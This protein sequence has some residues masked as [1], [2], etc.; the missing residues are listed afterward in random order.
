MAKGCVAA[1]QLGEPG[2]VTYARHRPEQTLLYRLVEQHYPA[3]LAELAAHDQFLPTYVQRE[4]EDYL[5]CGRLG[6]RFSTPALRALPPRTV[7]GVQLQ[8]LLGTRR[9][10]AAR[11]RFP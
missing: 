3:F 2:R 1:L 11:G 4:F 8:A 5:K 10:A 9:L 7:R 6:T